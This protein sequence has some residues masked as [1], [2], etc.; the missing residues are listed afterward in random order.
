MLTRDASARTVTALPVEAHAVKFC[1][2]L[3]IDQEAHR[4]YAD[5]NWAAGVDIFDVSGPT[6]TYLKT[7]RTRGTFNGIVI[8]PELQKVFVAMSSGVAVIDV[9][10]R[11][12]TAD[13]IVTT[14]E[15]GGRG[16]PD[17]IDYDPEHHL[18]YAP[19][20]NDGLM[21]II[22]AVA[23]RVV[24]EVGGLGGA[25]EQARY[26]AADG[27]VYLSGNADNVL[28][29]IDPLKGTL[30]RTLPIGE[31]CHPNGLAINPKTNRAVL[32][33][34]GRTT[35][36]VVFDLE[37]GKPVEVLEG[38]GGGDGA[39]Y[40]EVADRFFFA[41]AGFRPSPVVRVFDGAGSFKGNLPSGPFASW[42]AYDRT[43]QVLRLPT[44]SGGHPAILTLGAADL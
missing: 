10:P 35:H 4:L 44:I 38:E 23:Q 13:T 41:A 36:C 27:M 31:P 18:I 7:V 8:A 5:D 16:H 28:Y 11:S 37:E 26:N 32:A 40:D 6:P 19:N 14:I 21:S 15:V 3:E 9:D 30:V 1:D 42:V 12:P 33:N 22:D 34:S 39:V 43:N 24:R 17:L 20:R 29:Q 25:L 2:T